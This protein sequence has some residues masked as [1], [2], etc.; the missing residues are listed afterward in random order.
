[1]KLG[2]YAYVELHFYN[3]A[4]VV[5]FL[6]VVLAIFEILTNFTTKVAKILADFLGPYKTSL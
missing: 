4:F 6:F 5:V 1:M 3:G 2:S